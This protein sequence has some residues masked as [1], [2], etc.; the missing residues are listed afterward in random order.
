M[1]RTT[2]VKDECEGETQDTYFK[3][4]Y[5]FDDDGNIT[6]EYAYTEDTGNVQVSGEAGIN[7]YTG[8]RRNE[9]YKGF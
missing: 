1:V 2:Q 9:L 8:R 5:T 6:G 7:P 4:V 3:T